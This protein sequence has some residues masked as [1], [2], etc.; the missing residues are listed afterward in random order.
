[1]SCYSVPDEETNSSSKESEDENEI[2]ED[3]SDKEK[4]KRMQI[5]NLKRLREKVREE[6]EKLR[7]LKSSSN[8]SKESSA[9]IKETVSSNPL[10]NESY[11][12]DCSS[13][14]NALE[15]PK[16][17]NKI[18]QNM[19]FGSLRRYKLIVIP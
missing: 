14:N 12:A 4:L 1:M 11:D 8:H 17:V 7:I 15:S 18:Q 2:M 10:I 16:K 6:E 5:R 13:G 3:T 9:K 19:T